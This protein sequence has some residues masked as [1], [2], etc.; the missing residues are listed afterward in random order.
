MAQ[1]GERERWPRSLGR[2]LVRLDGFGCGTHRELLRLLAVHELQALHERP[3]KAR[4][5]C[6]GCDLKAVKG[7]KGLSKGSLRA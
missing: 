3:R 6:F 7:L 2:S 4:R 1:K 5:G